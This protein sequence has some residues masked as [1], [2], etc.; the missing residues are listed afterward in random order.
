MA[1]T[2]K[3]RAARLSKRQSF[4]FSLFC[5]FVFFLLLFMQKL[6]C[7]DRSCTC[8]QCADSAQKK[9]GDKKRKAYVVSSDED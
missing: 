6:N 3:M 9:G 1:R 5:F 8:G 2:R 4:A 7:C